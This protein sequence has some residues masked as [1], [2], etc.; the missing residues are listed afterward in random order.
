[1]P[2][3]FSP[4]L[5]SHGMND[6]MRMSKHKWLSLDQKKKDHQIDDKYKSIL[7][8]YAKSS[9]LSPSSNRPPS[10]PPYSNQLCHSNHH[11]ISAYDFLQAH[12][13]ELDAAVVPDDDIND[14]PPADQPDPEP[15]DTLLVIAAKRSQP[16]SLPP[17]DIRRVLSKSSKCAANF[18]H[19]E[20]KV[21][22]HK[23]AS[24]QSLSLIDCGSNG[25]VAGDDVRIISKTGRTDDIRGIDTH[26]STNVDIGT[27]VGVIQTQK[28]PSLVI[29]IN[30]HC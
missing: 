22:Y 27:V 17:G 26:Q 1:M 28:G 24:G 30:M 29:C 2:P 10:K 4:R 25:G 13:H 9:S 5:G 21:S 15:P 18:T 20:Y 12:V 3:S 6:R 8:G 23:A 14:V 7:L 19:I 11:D 16:T